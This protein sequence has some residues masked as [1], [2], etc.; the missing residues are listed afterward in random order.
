MLYLTEYMDSALYAAYLLGKLGGKDDAPGL[1][2]LYGCLEKEM[3]AQSICP[4][5]AVLPK[6]NLMDAIDWIVYR[7]LEE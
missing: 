6:R 5:S 4:C 3:A 2:K 1:L 7:D